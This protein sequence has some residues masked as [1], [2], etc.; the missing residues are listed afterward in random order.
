MKK[1][2]V[3]VVFAISVVFILVLGVVPLFINVDTFRPKVQDEISSAL[4]RKVTLGH[5]DLSLITGSLVADNITVAD[6]PA[7]A[8]EPFLEAKELRIGIALGSLI[9]HR[10]VQVTS[11]TVDSPAIH[12][13]QDKKGTW[14]FSSLGSAA[15][16]PAAENTAVEESAPVKA[17]PQKSEAGQAVPQ[18]AAA[19]ESTQ[20]QGSMLT[21]ASVGEIKIKNGS[22]TVSSLPEAGKPFIC[23]DINLSVQQLSFTTQFPFKLSLTLPGGGSFL[24]DGKAGPVAQKDVSQTP[25]QAALQLKHF[26]PVAAGVV[27]PSQGVSMIADFN[28]QLVSDGTT[29]TSKGKLVASKLQLARSGTPA[30]QPVDIEYTI[31]DNLLERTGKV[32]DI[33]IHTG[34]AV[35]HLTGGFRSTEKDTVLDINFSA[36]GLSI[37]QLSPLLPAAGITLPR[38]SK[39]QGGTLTANIAITGPVNALVISG[40]VSVDNTELTGFDLGSRIEGLNPFKSKTGGTAIEKLSAELKS[41]PQVTE[42]NNL[43]GSVPSIGTAT[44]SGAISPAD[45]LDFTIVAKLRDMSALGLGALTNESSRLMSI[46]GSGARSVSN[47]GVPITIT[48]TASDPHI[49]VNFGA[50]LKGQVTGASGKTS[51]QQQNNPASLLKGLFH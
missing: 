49:R 12:L 10:Q 31:S 1:R 51:G 46:I 45:A 4:G 34:T 8:T 2:W 21:S 30:T 41:S 3:K 6:D 44:G 20:Q 50:M 11:F 5:L 42:I 17:M 22:A 37:D 29:L 36:P 18:Q 15:A 35:A 13:I 32:T 39:L 27:A 16:T 19:Q 33:A 48:G 7:F 25:F 23:T 40:P 43:Y 26:S 14:N 24:L 9:F 38:G 47:N 28:V